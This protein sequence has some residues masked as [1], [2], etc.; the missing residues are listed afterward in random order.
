MKSFFVA[1]W[2]NPD[3]QLFAEDTTGQIPL[4]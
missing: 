2:S 3:N 4:D 1:P